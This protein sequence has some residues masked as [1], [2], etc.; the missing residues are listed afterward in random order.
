MIDRASR[1][2]CVDG[3][4]VELRRREMELLERLIADRDNYVSRE[5]LLA[6]LWGH[7]IPSSNTLHVHLS[8]L[9]AKLGESPAEPRFIHSCRQRGVMFSAQ[10]A[11]T[12]SPHHDLYVARRGRLWMRRAA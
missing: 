5:Q 3:R 10:R 7:D 12:F 2:V 4:R 8:R 11:H 6:D 9:R 1:S